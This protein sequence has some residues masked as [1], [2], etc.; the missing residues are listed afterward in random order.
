MTNKI[1]PP[2]IANTEGVTRNVRQLNTHNIKYSMSFISI[3]KD[4]GIRFMRIIGSTGIVCSNNNTR[5][6]FV[7]FDRDC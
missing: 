1:T 5:W 2:E 7:L 6:A 4:Y 3:I